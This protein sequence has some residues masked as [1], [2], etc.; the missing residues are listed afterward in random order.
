[1]AVFFV[2]ADLSHVYLQPSDS[3][4]VVRDLVA[5]EHVSS[6][7][8]V[9]RGTRF[10]LFG[11]DIEGR[12]SILGSHLRRSWR[13]HLLHDATSR[14]ALRRLDWMRSIPAPIRYRWRILV[15]H[16]T[17]HLRDRC[18]RCALPRRQDANHHH[19]N[20]LCRVAGNIHP[21][22]SVHQPRVRGHLPRRP[23]SFR[24]QRRQ[25]LQRNKRR[26]KVRCISNERELVARH[27][28]RRQ[29]LVGKQPPCISR[30]RATL[31]NG[32]PQVNHPRMGGR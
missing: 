14:Q 15:P 13:T 4:P 25:V 10:I 1:M 20:R 12:L 9:W 16:T 2:T 17:S 23:H 30:R 31:A 19:G 8:S 22:P 7:D 3:S 18:L 32:L 21:F 29:G 26:K 6:H 11:E 28:E 24:V 27:Q 5:E